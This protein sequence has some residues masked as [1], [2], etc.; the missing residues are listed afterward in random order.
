[1]GEH[2]ISRRA[3]PLVRTQLPPRAPRRR[4]LV[5]LV[6][7]LTPWPVIAAMPLLLIPA[8]LWLAP[9]AHG[10]I[11][12]DVVTVSVTW[13]GT[14]TCIDAWEPNP[15]NRRELRYGVICDPDRN[16]SASYV[17]HSGEWVGADPQMSGADILACTLA[18]NGQIVFSDGA[19]RNDGHQVSCL[20]KWW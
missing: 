10:I 14:P 20:R 8:G 18:V 4:G 9:D 7:R 17:A 5:G 16:V 11:R 15:D 2:I 13:T 19:A 12:Y 1:M 6:D 3:A